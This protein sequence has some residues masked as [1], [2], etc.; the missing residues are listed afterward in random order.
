MTLVFITPNYPPTICGVGDHTF[1]LVQAMTKKGHDVHVI[2]SANQKVKPVGEETI[3]A[4][5]KN[6]QNTEGVS[7]A[8]KI[9][10]DI[11]PNWVVVQ[12]V[13]HGLHPKG[14][15]FAI[16]SLYK[17]L[18]Q[19]NIPILT[20]FHEVRIRPEWGVKKQIA[21]FLQTKIANRIAKM[22]AKVVTSIDFYAQLLHHWQHKMTIVPVGSN[23]LPLEI[24]AYEKEQLKQKHSI[25]EDALVICTFGNRDVS[26]YLTAFD[27]LEKDYP[28]LIWLMAGKTKTPSVF[29]ESRGYIRYV[30]EMSAD[31]IYRHLSLGEVF[32][33]PDEINEKGE[34]GTSNKSGSLACACA[35]GIPI[36]ATKGDLNNALLI[37]NENILLIDITDSDV[38]YNTLKSCLEDKNR[39]F[40]LGKNARKLYDEALQWDAQSNQFL[41]LMT[42]DEKQEIFHSSFINS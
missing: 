36:V 34:G 8:T 27:Q 37:N 12:Y 11:K 13:P 18:V 26:P 29:L 28:N 24:S 35:L 17:K 16:L 32:F 22:S 38:L 9:I 20:V 40:H 31:D 21:S 15:P 7:V 33:M 5:V 23:I 1:H 10:A 19:L 39:R 14:L 3:H 4:V 42:L 6:W 2:C 41:S 30:G 25:N